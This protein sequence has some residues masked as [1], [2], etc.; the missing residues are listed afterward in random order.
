MLE[1]KQYDE[2]NLDETP[3]VVLGC[4]HFFT[5]ETLDGHMGMGEVYVQDQNGVYT[6]LKDTSTA[7]AIA[8]PQCPDCRCPVRQ[9]STQRYN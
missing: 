2:V 3:V 7:L 8:V 4:G 6:D 1:L 5:A 9:Y